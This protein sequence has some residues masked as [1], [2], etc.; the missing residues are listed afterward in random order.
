LRIEK[1][2]AAQIE[3]DKKYCPETINRTTVKKPCYDFAEAYHDKLGGMVEARMQA[4]ILAV[5]SAWYTAWVDAGQPDLDNLKMDS[6]I[7]PLSIKGDSTELAGENRSKNGEKMIG[8]HE[9][10]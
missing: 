4:A 7:G 1:E 10:Y 2:V 9:E 5:G 3:V 6:K 8:R